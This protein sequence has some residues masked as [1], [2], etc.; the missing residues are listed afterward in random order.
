MDPAAFDAADTCIRHFDSPLARGNIKAKRRRLFSDEDDRHH[1]WACMTQCVTI[2]QIMAGG[3][4]ENSTVAISTKRVKDSLVP[5]PC[6]SRIHLA[7]IGRKLSSLAPSLWT[8]ACVQSLYLVVDN[9]THK[10]KTRRY[11]KVVG[12]NTRNKNAFHYFRLSSL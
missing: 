2:G 8:P 4:P 3:L 7:I 5:T 12:I 1:T 11:F 10:G 6:H 9:D